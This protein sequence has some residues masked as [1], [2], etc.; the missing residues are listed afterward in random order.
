MCSQERSRQRID[1]KEETTRDISAML[2]SLGKETKNDSLSTAG[3]FATIKE[4]LLDSIA[5]SR[6][7]DREKARNYVI[8]CIGEAYVRLREDAVKKAKC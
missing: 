3:L 2:N 1:Q 5:T 8:T 6:K 7:I 4:M